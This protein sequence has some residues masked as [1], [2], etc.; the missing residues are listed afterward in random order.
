[1]AT[2]VNTV[3]INTLIIV[4]GHAIWSGARHS[5]CTPIRPN[6]DETPN[7]V[8]S[9]CSHDDVNDEQQWLIKDFQ[10]G[11]T[12]TFVKHIRIGMM[13]LESLITGNSPSQPVLVG[14]PELR[15]RWAKD[16][17]EPTGQVM[18]P[19]LCF[20]GGATDRAR[21][22]LSEAESYARVAEC[23]LHRDIAA[24]TLTPDIANEIGKRIVVEE[25]A[26]DSMQNILLSLIQFGRWKQELKDG[27]QGTWKLELPRYLMIVSHE[28]KRTRFMEFHLPVCQQ[29]WPWHPPGV[30]NEWT[31]FKVRAYYGLDP[32]LEGDKLQAL[33]QGDRRHGYEVWRRDIYGTGRTLT[34]KRIRRGW[35]EHE[36][37]R[38]IEEKLG[39]ELDK[40]FL[41]RMVKG[42]LGWEGAATHHRFVGADP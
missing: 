33:I 17:S 4:C 16:P 26:T 21:T 1:M 36:Y 5:D 3:D 28:F 14:P 32:P 2:D 34:T 29:L 12:G 35:D 30:E 37:V 39:P 9:V 13:L 19:L 8:R 11:E 38:F 20:S 25:W 41:R 15:I 10:Q 27:G 6:N 22:S 42:D 7:L 24:G 40:A 23:L 18:N 31:L